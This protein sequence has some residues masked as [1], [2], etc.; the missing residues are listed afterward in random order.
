MQL[1]LEAPVVCLRYPVAVRCAH[2]PLRYAEAVGPRVLERL[3][4]HARRIEVALD[5]KAAP[6]I[7]SVAD[8]AERVHAAAV[9]A[10][11]FVGRA[12]AHYRQHPRR[13]N[14]EPPPRAPRSRSSAPAEHRHR[15]AAAHTASP[16]HAG[17]SSRVGPT[18]C[19]V[20][21]RLGALFANRPQFSINARRQRA[22]T[23][24]APG[25]APPCHRPR[26]RPLG[27]RLPS[28]QRGRGVAV[29]QRGASP[30]FMLNKCRPKCTWHVE[31]AT[32]PVCFGRSCHD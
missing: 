4:H 31:F 15:C 28:E 2:V 23:R 9:L 17:H 21:K 7:G 5:R 8:T 11:I 3:A 25:P 13:R 12:H 29:R 26:R 24:P 27:R 19:Y 14:K 22:S 10:F 20:S 16:S 18:P 30:L 6:R 32:A 1:A